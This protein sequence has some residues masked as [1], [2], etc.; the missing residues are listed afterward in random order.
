MFVCVFCVSE[1]WKPAAEHGAISPDH[2][3][4]SPPPLALSPAEG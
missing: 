1:A 3:A 4:K 2:G